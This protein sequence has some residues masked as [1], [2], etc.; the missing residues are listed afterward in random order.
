M[1]VVVVDVACAV[2]VVVVD[3][4]A[5]AADV[6][7][8]AT[9]AAADGEALVAPAVG[10]STG[11]AAVVELATDS[12]LDGAA[13]ELGGAAD[14][15]AAGAAVVVVVVVVELELGTSAAL[16]GLLICVLERKSHVRLNTHTLF[17]QITSA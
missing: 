12:V 2:V 4:D 10:C 7:A 5:E 16:F 9:A 13:D 17:A 3:A 8:T 14:E 15:D 6:S 1:V 11:A